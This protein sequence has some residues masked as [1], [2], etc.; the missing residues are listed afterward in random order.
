M[1]TILIAFLIMPIVALGQCDWYFKGFLKSEVYGD[2]VILRN[3]SVSRN[4]GAMYTMQVYPVNDTLHWMQY[5]IGFA[6]MCI[7]NFN[8]SVTL[9]SLPAGTHIVKVYHTDYPGFGPPY[10]DTCY[11]GTMTFEVSQPN[12]PG[13]ITVSGGSQSDCFSY[14]TGVSDREGSRDLSLYPNPAGDRLNIESEIPGEKEV[15]ILD[16]TGRELIAER[17]TGL[18]HRLDI[19]HLA[20][21]SYVAR[22]SARELSVVRKFIRR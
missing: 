1:K 3:D 16:L 9:E 22:I 7:C 13:S 2:S 19:G 6:A 10:Y 18:V 21:G 12:P 15:V 20:P 11:V 4:C 8:L 5:D 17:F 14:P